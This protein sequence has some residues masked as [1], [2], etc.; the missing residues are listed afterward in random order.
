MNKR[1]V[2]EEELKERLLRAGKS[3][4]EVD[5]LIGKHID[6]T[7]SPIIDTDGLSEIL[8]KVQHDSALRVRAFKLS[9]EQYDAL[10]S[11]FEDVETGQIGYEQ[12]ANYL[13][14]RTLEEFINLMS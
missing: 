4:D 6:A 5:A 11:Y 2:T 8:R 10:V 12:D 13:V 9:K 3:T 7:R 1:P 14:Q